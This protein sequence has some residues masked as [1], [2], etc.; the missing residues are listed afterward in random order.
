LELKYLDYWEKYSKD[1]KRIPESMIPT[2]YQSDVYVTWQRYVIK[3]HGEHHPIYGNLVFDFDDN[4]DPNKSRTDAIKMYDMLINEYKINPTNI[5]IYFSGK[6][7]FH[8][9]IDYRSYMDE[10]EKDLHLIYKSF[11][12]TIK[13][14]FPTLDGSMYAKRKM[15]RLPNS[16]H[17]GSGLYCIPITYNQLNMT[18]DYIKLLAKNTQKIDYKYIKDDNMII[19]FN[20]MRTNMELILSKKTTQQRAVSKIKEKTNTL[21]IPEPFIIDCIKNRETNLIHVY[22]AQLKCNRKHYNITHKEFYELL[23]EYFHPSY[24]NQIL[25]GWAEKEYITYDADKKT[26][27]ILENL[28]KYYNRIG[29][30]H[31]YNGIL[32]LNWNE[33]TYTGNKLRNF[34]YCEIVFRNKAQSISR[35]NIEKITGLSRATQRVAEQEYGVKVQSQYIELDNALPTSRRTYKRDGKY[36]IQHV[37]CYKYKPNLKKIRRGQHEL[38]NARRIYSKK[39]TGVF[40]FTDD[41]FEDNN[42]I[43][44][45][46]NKERI[47]CMEY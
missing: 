25:K 1:W 13:D 36:Y 24:I 29:Y 39:G 17:S 47:G 45:V 37:N 27:A 38:D 44:R 42:K 32:K 5:R 4:D 3:E 20:D 6:K 40:L 9:E 33:I 16:I 11:Y 28:D 14:R 23:K 26:Y 12:K 31:K 22:K 30:N 43:L 2:S 34:M 15:W 7:G 46:S 10:P 21:G 41:C 8:I 18:M 19:L 35:A